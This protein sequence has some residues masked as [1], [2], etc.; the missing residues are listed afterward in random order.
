MNSGR[1]AWRERYFKL[2]FRARKNRFAAICTICAPK[3]SK[4]EL[5]NNLFSVMENGSDRI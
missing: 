3:I 1:A 2:V 4:P 5:W